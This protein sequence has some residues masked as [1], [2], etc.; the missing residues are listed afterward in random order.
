MYAP[1]PCALWR[2]GKDLGQTLVEISRDCQICDKRLEKKVVFSRELCLSDLGSCW[3]ASQSAKVSSDR[4][5]PR[6]EV[7]RT[8]GGLRGEL[9]SYRSHVAGRFGEPWLL[10]GPARPCLGLPL[11]AGLSLDPPDPGATSSCLPAGQGLFSPRP[12]PLL[13][14]GPLLS[15]FP[16]PACPPPLRP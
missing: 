7:V 9:A 10:V 4:R 6:S 5:E 13:A 11:K 8:G 1:T 3:A 12:S 14:R 15:P 2:A 16:A